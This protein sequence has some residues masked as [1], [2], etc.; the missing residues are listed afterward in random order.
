MSFYW[1][2][3]LWLL[4]LPLFGVVVD[5]G[6]KR[7]SSRNHHP[8]IVRADAAPDALDIVGEG[9]GASGGP[10][11]RWRFWLGLTLAIMALA[12]PQWG[13]I[14]E[15]VFDQSR[16]ILIAVDL[17]RSML[18]EDVRP[19][20]LDR[21]KLLITSLLERLEG[22]RVGLIVFAG[23]AFLQSPLSA[24]YEILREFLPTLG[25]DY[26]PQGGTDY[27]AL[28][29]TATE[30]FTAGSGADRFLIVLSDGESQTDTWRKTA[31]ELKD[32]NVRVIS[33]GIGTGEGA[34]LPDGQGGF[35]KDE[36]GAVVLSR[37]NATTLEDIARQTGGVYRNASSWVDLAALLQ[38][39]VE[40]GRQGEFTETQY[41][42]L[43]ERFQWAL[44][45]ALLFFWWSFW[46][47]FPVHP[48]SRQITLRAKGGRA[49]AVSALFILGLLI[50]LGDGSSLRAQ[51]APGG[52]DA[53][54]PLAGPLVKTIGRLSAAGNL[55]AAD[56]AELAQSTL[57]YGQ[58]MLT[59]RQQPESGAIRDALA[60][61]DAGEALDPAAADWADLRR[62]LQT[63]LKNPEDEQN[64]GEDESEKDQQDQ[65]E[66]QPGEGESSPDE[67]GQKG[68]QSDPSKPSDP[69][70]PEDAEQSESS[71]QEGSPEGQEGKDQP[72]P[73]RPSD[74]AEAFGDMNESNAPAQEEPP[75][76]EPSG[77]TQTVGGQPDK[78]TNPEQDPSMTMPLQKLDQLRQ[79]DSPAKLYQLMQDPK[80][81]PAV[82]GRDW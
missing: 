31:D 41:V 80:A 36:R 60:G 15:P 23:T 74:P 69:N 81:P 48:R 8:K 54:D 19:S 50:V 16:E 64:S 49:T 27:E 29:A 73:Q 37:L 63:F 3:L 56:Y 25:P 18:A 20:R 43:A 71:D 28:L 24:D 12:R 10:R 17:S 33:L 30:A 55:G 51:P 45:P 79:Q 67:K 34:M 6:R 2:H 5:L 9:R 13:R 35:I 70:N 4:A 32:R 59:T 38:Q 21:A 47:E 53:P 14:E 42:R 39:T 66:K 44:A 52:P 75:P 76:P 58:R 1:P 11:F 77:D 82:K 40:A 7:R 26:L 22:E 65:S 61:V 68:D 57:T 46:R 78:P 62:K 72:Q